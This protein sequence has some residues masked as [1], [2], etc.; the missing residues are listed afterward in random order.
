MTLAAEDPDLSGCDPSY[1]SDCDAYQFCERIVDSKELDDLDGHFCAARS[2]VLRDHQAFPFGVMSVVDTGI[3]HERPR[4]IFIFKEAS[5]ALIAACL[6]VG[7]LPEPATASGPEPDE[8]GPIVLAG[9]ARILGH[10]QRGEGEAIIEISERDGIYRGVIVWSE[11]RPETVGNEV[12]RELRYNAE[13][14]EWHG[15]AYSIKRKREVPIDIGVPTADDLELTAHIM[16]FKKGVDFKRV[17][18]A[19]VAARTAVRGL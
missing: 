8:P 11:R 17:P 19:E 7:S 3:R 5:V 16:I 1:S 6:L 12:F 15:R 13:E 10:W 18:N 4:P 14:R 9:E 2:S